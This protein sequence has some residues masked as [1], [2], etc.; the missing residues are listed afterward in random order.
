MLIQS[1]LMTF[2]KAKKVLYE[3]QFGF[4][5]NHS[6]THALSAITE[7]IGQACDSGSFACGVFFD[8]QNAF[9]TVN[10]GILLKKLELYH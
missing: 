4:V 8:F 7:K 10:H 5:H 2:W 1:H 9:D 3:K 6:I